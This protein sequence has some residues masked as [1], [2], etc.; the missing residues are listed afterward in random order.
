MIKPDAV[1]AGNMG[2]ILAMIEEAGF[3]VIH[4]RLLKFTEKSAGQFYEIHQGKG[5]YERLIQFMVKDKVL[6][7]VLE[8]ENAIDDLRDLMGPTDPKNAPKTTVRGRYAK[9]MPDNAIH[10]SDSVE[11]A[12]REITYIFGEYAAIPSVEK[13]AAK[14]Y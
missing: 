11:S 14:E 1:A 8:K 5:F 4:A 9:G 2:N 6:A 7:L 3:D 10:G 12:K 13:I